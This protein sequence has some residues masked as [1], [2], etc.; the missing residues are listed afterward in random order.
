MT[1]PEQLSGDPKANADMVVALG[2]DF[3]VI[4]ERQLAKLKVNFA[5]SELIID[6]LLGTGVSGRVSSSVE[7]VITL[8]NESAC[9]VLSIDIPS[10]LD[11]KSGRPMGVCVQADYTVTFGAPKL[12]MVQYPAIPFV[13][14]L[15]IADIGLPPSLFDSSPYHL[16]TGSYVAE[17]LPARP[18]DA[19]KG[20]FGRLFILAGSVGMTGAAS[21]TT[22]AA[23]RSGA[24]LVTL[25]IPESLNP[26]LEVK[27][28]ES[29]TMPLPE[30]PQGIVGYRARDRIN[31][32][33]SQ[34]DA[35]AVGPGLTTQGEIP[36]LVTDL[37][38]EHSIPAVVDADGLNG[39]AQTGGVE[40]LA[41]PEKTV[42]TPHP[43]EL[44]R[45]LHT[46]IPTIQADRVEMAQASA[47]SFGTVV[48]LKG[49]RTIVAG[50]DGSV[51]INPTGNSGMATG[52]S[53]DALTGIIAALLAQGTP[54]L[55]AAVCGVYVHGLAGDLAVKLW[56]NRSLVPSDLIA[57]LGQAFQEIETTE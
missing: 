47:M 34:C 28:T 11:A 55:A 44:A 27:L 40:R 9:P 56:G 19:H 2:L 1:S 8:V 38:A 31:Q 23:L 13:G 18:A 43:G 14:Q 48:V 7:E 6:G 52:G 30:E 17:H 46:D 20:I 25:A 37:L 39:L 53:G 57:C 10:G 22:E 4:Q 12:G 16:V 5:A 26:I 54:A 45:L 15:I 35:W 32:F 36:H 50:P 49:A 33:L 24:G 21:L 42:L 3:D 41:A 29:M 51:Y